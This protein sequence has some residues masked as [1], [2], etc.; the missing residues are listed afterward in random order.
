MLFDGNIA[1]EGGADCWARPALPAL[2]ENKDKIGEC[3]ASSS[4]NDVDH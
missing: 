2:D 4:S 3:R 1:A